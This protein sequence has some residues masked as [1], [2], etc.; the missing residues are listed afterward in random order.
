[1]R[2]PDKM[3]LAATVLA[4]IHAAALGA[5][6]LAPYG[7]T[8]QARALPYA[9]PTRLHVVDEGGRF[10]RRPFVYPLVDDEAAAGR[11]KEDRSQP[12]PIHFLVRG[13]DELG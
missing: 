6:F 4:A 7:P 5:G 8:V 13:P 12:F 3:A 11:Y 9:P 2:R 1:M 10:H